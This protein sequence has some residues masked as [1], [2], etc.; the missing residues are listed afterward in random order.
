MLR[1]RCADC[2]APISVRYPLVELRD[3][4]SCSWPST[5]RIADLHLLPALPAFLCFTAIAIALSMIDID[6]QR[7]PNASCCRPIRCLALALTLAAVILDEP[8]ALVRAA[9]C[10]A[11]LF[12]LYFVLA[13]IYPKGM[14]FGDVKLAGIIGGMLGF[15]SYSASC[16]GASSARFVIGG[17]FG[18]PGHRS[19]AEVAQDRLPFG[20]FMF[21]GA[22]LALFWPIQPGSLYSYAALSA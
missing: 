10:G 1:G 22:L 13:F 16:I 4:R 15:L 11:A 3:R 7:L 5:W 6:V 17:F 9:I 19:G 12:P 8:A 2:Q 20:P 21:A 18:D 14:G